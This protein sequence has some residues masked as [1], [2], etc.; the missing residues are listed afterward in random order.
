MVR[1]SSVCWGTK[2]GI[3]MKDVRKVQDEMQKKEEAERSRTICF[4]CRPGLPCFTSCCQDVNI[5]LSPY[6]IL[7]MKN[8][9]K[10][11]SGSFLET[12]TRTLLPG[13]G[14]I[15]I[16]L[17]TMRSEDKRC[18]FVTDEGCSIYEDRPWAC[19]MYPL[20][21]SDETGEY[22][23][24]VDPEKC[25]GQKENVPWVLKDWFEDQGLPPYDDMDMRFRLVTQYPRLLEAGI[26][27]PQVQ[28]MFRMACYDL[29]TFRRFVHE[30]RFF[31]LFEVD[32]EVK[33]RIVS[34]DV[35]LLELAINWLRFGLV[36]G[37]VLPIKKEQMKKGVP[38][39]RP[40]PESGEK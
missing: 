14:K 13:V 34:D 7:R 39:D 28:R 1:V 24:I 31:D 40:L 19:R 30:T 20:D 36:C 17:L 2:K 22:S 10:I 23:F 8:R 29:D 37:D 33:E 38:A 35:A 3:Q 6:D 21:K 12:Y 27:Q 25:Q 18:H 5:F 15:P 9:L 26:D 32:E 16:I 4:Q 11:S